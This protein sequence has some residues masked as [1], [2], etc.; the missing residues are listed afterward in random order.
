MNPFVGE[1]VGTALLILLG[2]GIVAGVLL[3]R[4]KAHGAGWLAITCGWAVAVCVGVY[5]AARFGVGHLNPAVTVSLALAEKLPWE[6]VPPYLGGQFAGAFLG[7]VLVW[8]AYLPHWAD[9]AD[10]DAKLAVF[11]TAP[12]I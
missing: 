8:L 2:D 6:E 9:T 11:C 5:A 4:S 1:L 10:A 3:G 12:A 7:A